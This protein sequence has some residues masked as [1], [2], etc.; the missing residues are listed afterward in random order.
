M[1]RSGREIDDLLRDI[2]PQVL[3]TLLRRH[4]QFELCEDA[5]QDALVEATAAW[6][7]RGLPDNP[8]AWLVTVANR[9]LID[10]V[11]SES[12]RR[13]REA[14]Q[15]VAEP[16][17]SLADDVA[18]EADDTLLLLLLCCHPAITEASQIALTL[19]AVCG[20]TTA[21]IAAAFLVPEATM[22]QRISRS[23]QRIAAAGGRFERPAPDAMAERLPAVMH[24]LYLMFNEGY[25]ASSGAA[26][27]RADL[28]GEAIRLT[29]LLHELLPDDDEVAGL[30]ALMLV[31][32]ARR[33][34]R[35]RPDGTLVALADQDRS[36]WDQAEIAE[37][38]ALV[39]RILPK[40]PI[41]PYQLQAAI[42]A[43]HSE[44]ASV[45]DT[46]WLE[47]VALYDLLRSIA[48]NPMVTLNRSVALAMVA[49]PQPALDELDALADDPHLAE[50]HRLA[51][52]RGHLLE[53]AG[54]REEARVAFTTA[55]SRTRSQPE[56]IELL[57]RAA[58]LA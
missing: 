11:R 29:R 49:G 28:T 51:A 7:E 44:A 10:R 34:A 12:S 32:E 58:R 50:H 48:P 35:T 20:L 46:D 39:E 8:R 53:M 25:A 14:A 2:T 30:L 31:T 1:T 17:A 9:R 3:A 15:A 33:P 4:R 19:R 27:V 5:V 18:G 55:A 21:E 38:V 56:R 13:S 24:A 42:A 37:G 41:G 23:K 6:P 36:L 22:A 45:D 47:I 40:G 54:R 16:V 43:V 52:V 57:R 26:V